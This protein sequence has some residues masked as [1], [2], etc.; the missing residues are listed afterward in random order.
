MERIEE[1]CRDREE[2]Q[3]RNEVLETE[4]RDLRREMKTSKMKISEIEA[5]NLA[6]QKSNME[7]NEKVSFC[8]KF[9]VGLFFKV[10]FYVVE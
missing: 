2:V 7:L 10:I 5:L 4:V 8:F 3:N 1:E 9:L 6:V